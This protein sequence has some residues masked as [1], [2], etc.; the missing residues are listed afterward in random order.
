MKYIDVYNN[1]KNWNYDLS[2]YKMNKT[3]ASIV[4]ELLEEKLKE[5]KDAKHQVSI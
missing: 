4:M 3:E 2:S 5:D 1:L